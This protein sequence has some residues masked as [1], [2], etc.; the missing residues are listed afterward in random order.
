MKIAV[1]SDER[2]HVTDAVVEHL[3]NKGIEVELHGRLEGICDW[4]DAG[5]DETERATIAK[6]SKL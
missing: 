4:L 6:V 3:Q 1:G 2:A 5:P